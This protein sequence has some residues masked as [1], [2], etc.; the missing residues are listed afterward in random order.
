M[1][2]EVCGAP[3]RQKNQRRRHEEWRLH[4]QRTVFSMTVQ[5]E[6]F[7]VAAISAVTKSIAR[8]AQ[9]TPRRSREWQKPIT[10]SA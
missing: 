6:L 7:D 2:L 9:N 5:S 10:S 3:A 8:L 4:L 1:E